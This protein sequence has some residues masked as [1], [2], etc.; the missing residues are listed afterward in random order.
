MRQ[1][2]WFDFSE[3]EPGVSYIG[4]I[5]KTTSIVDC[6]ESTQENAS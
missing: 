2:T 6:H 5:D 4:S 1:S 3:Q